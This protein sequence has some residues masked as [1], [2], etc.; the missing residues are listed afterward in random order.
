MEQLET[1]KSFWRREYYCAPVWMLAILVGVIY[2]VTFT[3]KMAD[4]DMLSIIAI[5]FSIGLVLY[6]LGERIPIWKDYL[7]G[8]SMLAFLGAAALE[9]YGILPAMY[10]ESITY[11]YDDYGFQTIF[12]S[13]LIV[14]AVLGVTR[15]WTA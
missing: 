7:G 12:I 3:G 10:C 11:F 4:Q 15:S 13:L 5:M 1:K 9:F 2:L 6:E 8:G 14:S